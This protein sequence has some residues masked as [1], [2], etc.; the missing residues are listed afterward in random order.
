MKRLISITLLIVIV[1]LSACVRRG[2]F[3]YN[4]DYVIWES[5]EESYLKIKIYVTERYGGYGEM[6]H[7]GEIYYF[8][9]EMSTML[10][11]NKVNDRQDDL[12]FNFN[13][14]SKRK[15]IL[16]KYTPLNKH[17][18]NFESKIVKDDIFDSYYTG[19]K[20]IL[21]K[22]ALDK[23][24]IT[25][26]KITNVQYSSERYSLV[27]TMYIG[28]IQALDGT[29]KINGENQD[30]RLVFSNDTEFVIHKLGNPNEVLL[31]GTYENDWL[32]VVLTIT[33]NNIDEET[34]MNLT[35]DVGIYRK[36]EN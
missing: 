33:E 20:V 15:F 34:T 5:T 29:M 27:T 16:T 4:Y 8:D 9:I 32:D 1:F 11:V 25:S 28:Y 14:S 12:D 18:G 24:E 17:N 13:L 26:N 2:D 31:K 21:E 23:N 3:A 10:F 30:V 19:K 6:E 7:L 35:G 22:R 36:D